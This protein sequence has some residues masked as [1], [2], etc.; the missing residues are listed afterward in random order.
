[1][2][3]N[4]IGLD[5]FNDKGGI[6]YFDADYGIGIQTNKIDMSDDRFNYNILRNKK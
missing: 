5:I 6:K 3:D 4:F 1:M 2:R